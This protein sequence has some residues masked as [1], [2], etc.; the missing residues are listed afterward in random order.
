MVSLFE[1][2]VVILE[3]LLFY[4]LKHI[5]NLLFRQVFKEIY[6]ANCFLQL[7]LQFILVLLGVLP[8]FLIKVWESADQVSE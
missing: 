2:N 1:H 5:L 6:V 8:K 4:L 3:L 7:P